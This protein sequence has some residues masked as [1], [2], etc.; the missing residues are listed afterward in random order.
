MCY[1][2]YLCATHKRLFEDKIYAFKYG[3]VVESVYEAYKGM[4]DIEEGLTS[5]QHLDKDYE[6]MPVRRCISWQKNMLY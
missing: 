5:D 4:K 3:P 6:Q 2:D 1:A